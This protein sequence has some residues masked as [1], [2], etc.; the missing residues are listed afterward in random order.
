VADQRKVVIPGRKIESHIILT[1]ASKN[2][3]LAIPHAGEIV[4]VFHPR[5]EQTPLARVMTY[6]EAKQFAE[7]ITRA[8]Q[9]MSD[10]V[11]ISEME[12]RINEQDSGD[13]K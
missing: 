13:G 1:D 7:E 10:D 11:T 2:T 9:A 5:G 4:V 3:V 8:H 6:E 12:K